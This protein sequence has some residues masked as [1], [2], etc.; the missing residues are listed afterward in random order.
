[1]AKDSRCAAPLSLLLQ[2][3][4]SLEDVLSSSYLVEMMSNTFV[5]AS[6]GRHSHC[7]IHVNHIALI[8]DQLQL[9]R[10]TANMNC[11]SF[12]VSIVHTYI[13]FALH[14]QALLLLQP[15]LLCP[16]LAACIAYHSMGESVVLHC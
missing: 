3:I 16:T 14:T 8:P 1:M 13:T 15:E 4:A 7:V 11:F 6:C 9:P 10:R 12:G 5:E 2:T